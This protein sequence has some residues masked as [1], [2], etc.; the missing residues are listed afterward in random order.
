[1]RD[2]LY[3]A[4]RPEIADPV[5]RAQVAMQTPPI[6][7]F[8]REAAV[9][10]VEGRHHLLLDG[11]QAKTPARRALSLATAEAAALLAAEWQG[12]GETIRPADMPVTRLANTG[13]D[14]VAETMPAVARDIATYAGSDLVCYRAGEPAGLAELQRLHWDPVIAFARRRLGAR[15]HMAEGV[16]PVTQ[17]PASIAAVEAAVAGVSDPVA[18][19]ALHVLTTI[20]GSALI[21]LMLACGELAPEAAFEAAELDAEWSR[22]TW[23]EDGEAAAR[24]ALRRRDFLVAATLFSALVKPEE[25]GY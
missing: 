7:R 6:R 15:F 10:T 20:G 21:T 25:L 19:A 3:P 11:R 16:M 24:A 9:G 2:I 8:Y 17:E 12:Q 13:L 14:T 18:L 5:R 23:G 22:R 4:H 1:M